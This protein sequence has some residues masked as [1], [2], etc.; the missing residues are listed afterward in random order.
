MGA[1]SRYDS[2]HYAADWVPDT[3]NPNYTFNPRYAE[4]ANADYAVAVR[5]G[6]DFTGDS[7]AS[8]PWPAT[9]SRSDDAAESWASHSGRG[10]NLRFDKWHDADWLLE[11]LRC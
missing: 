9:D 8:H 1:C 6:T 11:R 7:C 3:G 4:F 2:Q 5:T 10:S